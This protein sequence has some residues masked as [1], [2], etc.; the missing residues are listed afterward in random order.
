[1]VRHGGHTE[2][3]NSL[4]TP[5][6]TERNLG[7]VEYVH[8]MPEFQVCVYIYIYAYMYIY[9]YLYIHWRSRFCETSDL[10]SSA[11]RLLLLCYASVGSCP[12]YISIHTC[13]YLCTCIGELLRRVGM[14][15]RSFALFFLI[16]LIGVR[17]HF[18]CLE[19]AVVPSKGTR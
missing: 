19:T 4:N 9:I 2:W 1:M 10:L 7:L 8:F 12:G 5:E 18:D 3:G 11:L 14:S 17:C 16:A 13:I 6:R 15:G